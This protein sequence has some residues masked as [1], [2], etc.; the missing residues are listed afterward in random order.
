MARNSFTPAQ[1]KLL[2]KSIAQAEL[3]TSGEIRLHIEEELNAPVLDRAAHVFAELG[4]HK[5]KLRNGVLIYLALQSQQFAILGDKGI[6]SV[7]P[8]TFWEEVKNTMTD[9]FTKDDIMRGLQAGIDMAGKAL[10]AYYPYN[11]LTDENELP[12]EV[13]FN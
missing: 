4:L 1:I 3:N 12:N 13:S 11:K 8:P 6:N 5:T 9:H 7:V 10:G 2:E